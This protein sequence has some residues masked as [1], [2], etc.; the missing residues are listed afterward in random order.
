MFSGTSSAQI[1]NLVSEI[2]L[3]LALSPVGLGHRLSRTLKSL[4][5]LKKTF[6]LV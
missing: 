5:K 6:T 1:F 4:G 2:I 3:A